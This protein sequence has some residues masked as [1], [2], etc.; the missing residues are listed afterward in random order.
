MKCLIAEL[1]NKENKDKVCNSRKDIQLWIF[2]IKN[3]HIY[4]I[5]WMHYNDKTNVK[6]YADEIL[7]ENVSQTQNKFWVMFQFNFQ[8]N[9]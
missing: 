8:V 3:K 9:V 4:L 6:W 5:N 2:T 1:K 7:D